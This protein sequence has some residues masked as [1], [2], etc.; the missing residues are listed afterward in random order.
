MNL[1]LLRDEE[2]GSKVIQKQNVII[3]YYT[4]LIANITVNSQYNNEQ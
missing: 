2:S 4:I 3:S 1:Q